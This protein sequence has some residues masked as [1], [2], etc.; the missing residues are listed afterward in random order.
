[1]TALMTMVI[2][3]M[4]MEMVI[5]VMMMEMVTM[6]IMVMMVLHLSSCLNP[7]FSRHSLDPWTQLEAK[8]YNG[9]QNGHN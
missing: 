9:H 5:M 7:I 4:M 6:V 1:M 3:L 2:T 8:A